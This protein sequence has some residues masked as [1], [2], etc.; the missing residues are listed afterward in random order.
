MLLQMFVLLE[1]VLRAHGM[2]K[3]FR[4]L[5][6]TVIQAQRSEAQD[7]AWGSKVCGLD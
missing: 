5:L 2:W 1:G 6:E 3:E 4:S 7:H